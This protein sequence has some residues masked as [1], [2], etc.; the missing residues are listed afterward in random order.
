MNRIKIADELVKIAK[1][2]VA[3]DSEALNKLLE[4][5]SEG[6]AVL[7][8]REI[9]KDI[10][11]IHNVSGKYH[12]SV[13]HLG[14]GLFKGNTESGEFT[15]D[16]GS[17]MNRTGEIS[18]TILKADKDV[19]KDLKYDL[20]KVKKAL[21]ELISVKTAKMLVSE[22]RQPEVETTRRGVV[23]FIISYG[24]KFKTPALDNNIAFDE[25]WKKHWQDVLNTAIHRYENQ[26][27]VFDKMIE[28]GD[29]SEAGKDRFGREE[30]VVKT[31]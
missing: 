14:Y 12:D 30:Y 10:P 9:H 28:R 29:V 13:D 25:K 22:S 15:F 2:L 5:V 4:K 31:A 18:W 19:L 23:Y 11:T 24:V 26:K 21:E 17:A 3:D 1:M 27:K 6:Q 8:A 20:K 7:T 16:G